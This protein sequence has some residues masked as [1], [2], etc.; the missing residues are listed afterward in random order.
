M[1]FLYCIGNDDLS[2]GIFLESE[3]L[4]GRFQHAVVEFNHRLF[5]FGIETVEKIR[6]GPPAESDMKHLFRFGNEQE[7]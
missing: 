5:Q 2:P 7:A 6:D 3:K 4:T 1:N